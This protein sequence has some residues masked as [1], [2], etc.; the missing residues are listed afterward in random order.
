M[1]SADDTGIDEL[2][3]GDGGQY[4]TDEERDRADQ[5]IAEWAQRWG[6]PVVTVPRVHPDV[7]GNYLAGQPTNRSYL[8][9][10]LR[11]WWRKP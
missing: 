7:I 9:S 11:R 2:F 3:P 4:P 6:E 1:T 8:R 5:F 10:Q